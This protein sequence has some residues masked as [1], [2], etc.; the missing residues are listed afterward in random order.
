VLCEKDYQEL[1]DKNESLPALKLV[2]DDLANKEEGDQNADKFLMII[3]LNFIKILLILNKGKFSGSIKHLDRTMFKQPNQ[4]H[5]SHYKIG[6]DC[7]F[8]LK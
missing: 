8:H 7:E 1:K 6:K 4:M 3:S 2:Q 5:D